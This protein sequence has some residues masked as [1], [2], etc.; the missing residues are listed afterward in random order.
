M[1]S[2]ASSTSLLPRL[3]RWDAAALSGVSVWWVWC[4]CPG[5]FAIN[6]FFLCC[7]KEGWSFKKLLV[8]ML[9]KEK[10]KGKKETPPIVCEDLESW[11]YVPLRGWTLVSPGPANRYLRR[12]PCAGSVREAQ[13]QLQMGRGRGSELLLGTAVFLSD[14]LYSILLHFS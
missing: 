12:E 1:E 2:F 13:W 7:F 9:L 11:D 10:K 14:F 8:L 5:G 3:W 6:D 4:K